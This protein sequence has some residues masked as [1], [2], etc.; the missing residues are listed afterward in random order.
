MKALFSDHFLQAFR[1]EISAL[2]E[3]RKKKVEEHKEGA[4]RKI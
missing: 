4:G 1:T 3:I 2:P